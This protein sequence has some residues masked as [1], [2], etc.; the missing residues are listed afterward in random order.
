MTNGASVPVSTSSTSHVVC[1]MKFGRCGLQ[2]WSHWQALA[3][4]EVRRLWLPD[5]YWNIVLQATPLWRLC[6]LRVWC[7]TLSLHFWSHWMWLKRGA[8]P[9]PV[10]AY[11]QI[12]PTTFAFE[13][14]DISLSEW[15]GQGLLC[16]KN[17]LWQ[18]IGV[19][20]ILERSF[21][22][23]HNGGKFGPWISDVAE[24]HDVESLNL[25]LQ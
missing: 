8:S 21:R 17:C 10:S 3:L 2:R 20:Q 9:D 23:H 22:H 15:L 1:K 5:L 12:S 11:C 16:S 6:D 13:C 7:L 24:V 19:A 18:R 14:L 25:R 4:T